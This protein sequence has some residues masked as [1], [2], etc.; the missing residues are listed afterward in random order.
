MNLNNLNKFDKVYIELMQDI[1]EN[2][3]T[4]EDRTGVGTKSVF[5]RLLEFNM[6]DNFP[7]LTTKKVY[8]KGV[9]H[10]LLW[11]LKGDTN[12]KYLVDNNVHIWNGNA[13]EYYK[14][15]AK[16]EK[17]IL[18]KEKFIDLVKKPILHN[19]VNLDGTPY[20]YGDLGCVYGK[21]WRAWESKDWTKLGHNHMKRNIIDQIA[22]VIYSLKYNPDSRRHI[23]SAWNVGE[24]ENM[25][26]PPCHTMFQ[27]YSEPYIEEQDKLVQGYIEPKRKLSLMFTMRSNDFF[28]GAPF[29]IAS[30]GLLLHMVAQ[31]TNHSVGTLKMSIGDCHLYTNHIKQSKKQVDIAMCGEKFDSPKLWLNPNIKD[32]DCFTYEDIKIIDY[33]SHP[34][35]KA[36]MAV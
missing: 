25:A 16:E 34:S 14:V 1:L 17:E 9:I 33:K 15:V 26:L 29:N 7:L 18:S 24:V 22:N 32:I 31:V 19:L 2:G 11:F 28:L 13:Y 30:Y 35:I 8:W 21:Q 4:K 12:I 23:V 36:D 3:V 20:T 10:E 5:G 6:S 27:F